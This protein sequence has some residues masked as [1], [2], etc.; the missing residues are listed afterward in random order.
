MQKTRVEYEN[1]DVSL[2]E[3]Q[4]AIRVSARSLTLVPSILN[5]LAPDFANSTTIHAALHYDSRFDSTP[6]DWS[7]C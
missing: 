5:I 3:I 7:A 4:G 6:P 1:G 2:E